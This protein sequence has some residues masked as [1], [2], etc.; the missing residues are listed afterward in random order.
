[1]V[2]QASLL[3]VSELIICKETNFGKSLVLKYP[4]P[5]VRLRPPTTHTPHEVS[6]VSQ[7]TANLPAPT[8]T[9]TVL[10]KV[11]LEELKASIADLEKGFSPRMSLPLDDYNLELAGEP[12]RGLEERGLRPERGLVLECRL[13]KIGQAAILRGLLRSPSS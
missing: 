3:V 9:I 5:T 2:S 4:V 7:G 12:K 11:Y 13:H 1:M 10:N 8:P 6:T